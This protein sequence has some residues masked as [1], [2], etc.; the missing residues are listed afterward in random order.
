MSAA[1]S[2]AALSGAPLGTKDGRGKNEQ[3]AELC[4]LL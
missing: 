3:H 2:P 4:P 1:E